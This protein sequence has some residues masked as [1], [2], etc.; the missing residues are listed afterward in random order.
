MIRALIVDDEDLARV[1][2]RRVL[3]GEENVEVIG[4]AANGIDALEKI[5]DLNPDVVFLDIEMPGLNGMEVARNMTGEP[6]SGPLIVFATAYDEFAVKAFEANALDYLLKPIQPQ[7]VREALGRVTAA[8]RSG[9]SEYTESLTQV[10]SGVTLNKLAVRR[11]KRIVLLALK[12][13]FQI[14][15]EDKLVFVHTEKERFLIERTI[16]DLEEMLGDSGFL[17]IS[18][19]EV[20]NLEHVRELIPWFSGTWR[21]KL[22]NSTELDVSRDRARRLKE[23]MGV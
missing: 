23:I 2:L 18:R 8:L 5:G 12:E 4:E 17:R 16:G 20:V 9:R 15:I 19:G 11:G 6:G 13:I 21:V 10:L 14:S 1:N 3:D 7:R 22:S